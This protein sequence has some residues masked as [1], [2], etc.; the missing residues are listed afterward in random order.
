MSCHNLHPYPT[1]GGPSPE[2]YPNQGPCEALLQFPLLSGH[3]SDVLLRD[4]RP[5]KLPPPPDLPRLNH[6]P[7]TCA[8]TLPR[9]TD[10]LPQGAQDSPHPPTSCFYSPTLESVPQLFPPGKPN[11]LIRQ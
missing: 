5:C 2:R 6:F 1:A 7:Q 10:Q 11:P 8:H 3:S 4:I 9:P